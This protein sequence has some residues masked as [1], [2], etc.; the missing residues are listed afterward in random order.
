MPSEF[1][2]RTPPASFPQGGARLG[3]APRWARIAGTGRPAGRRADQ[4]RTRAPGGDQRR[5]DPHPHRHSPA[6][7]R[8]GGRND[9]GPRAARVA[10]RDCRSRDDAGRHRPHHRGDRHAGHDFSV[11]RM[12]PAGQ[13]RR[14]RRA[15]VRRRRR[16]LGLCLRARVRRQDGRQRRLAQRAGRRRRDLFADTRLERSRHMRAVRRRRGRRGRRA[17]GGA[18]H[19]DLAPA[20][21]RQLSQY[22]ERAGTGAGRQGH[23]HAVRPHGRQRR[24]QV[25]GQGAGRRRARS[26]VRRQHAARRHRLGDSAPG[27]YPHHGR[28]DEEAAPAA[29]TAHRYR[30]SARQYVGG[31]DSDGAR[32]RRCA[33]DASRPATTS[34]CSASAAASRGAR[35]F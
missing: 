3:A 26:A 21:R 25:R 31:V 34:C 30:R 27:Q 15:R 5:M 33:T 32:Y 2:P 13:A 22:P 8:G 1:P 16:M 10:R 14:S 19:P 35:I 20:R 7:H 18:R 28:H 6:A 23:G 9:V 17:I 24:V 4:R 12:H 29:R 11:D